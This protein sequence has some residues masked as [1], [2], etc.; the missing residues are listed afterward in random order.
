MLCPH[1]LVSDEA[2]YLSTIKTA[3]RT[4]DAS[5]I[6]EAP[7]QQVESFHIVR[8]LSGTGQGD[9]PPI[10]I[11]FDQFAAYLKSNVEASAGT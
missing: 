9:R 3:R 5:Q 2:M 10:H 1:Y 7:N 6:S 8:N 4:S 11:S